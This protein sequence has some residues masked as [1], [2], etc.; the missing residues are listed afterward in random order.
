[1]DYEEDAM[2]IYFTGPTSLGFCVEESRADRQD[3]L[4]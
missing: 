4:V 2:Q 1:M 3:S